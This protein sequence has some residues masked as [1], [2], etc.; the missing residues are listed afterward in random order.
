MFL[1]LALLCACYAVPAHGVMPGPDDPQ[2][3]FR[4][5]DGVPATLSAAKLKVD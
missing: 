4:L 2:N 1:L 3:P 5:Q